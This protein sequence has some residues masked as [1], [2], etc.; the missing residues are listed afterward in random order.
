[1]IIIDLN[2][3]EEDKRVLYI[4]SKLLDMELYVTGCIIDRGEKIKLIT[5]ND[6]LDRTEIIALMTIV[7]LHGGERFTFDSIEVGVEERW[8]RGRDGTPDMY[9][10][11]RL[12][13]VFKVES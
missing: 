6:Y 5:Y 13:G 7:L 11:K 1:M 9:L 4:G 3:V 8:D 2:E 12:A 10:V